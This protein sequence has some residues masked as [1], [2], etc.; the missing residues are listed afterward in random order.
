MAA[1]EA[2][3]EVVR[4]PLGREL[5]VTLGGSTTVRLNGVLA[6]S[7]LASVTWT[8]KLFGPT[9]VGVPEIA[10]VAELRDNPAGKVPEE[11]DQV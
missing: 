2:L 5:V 11:I 9:A 4:R 10:P 7:E 3:Y 6:D 1:R 8:V